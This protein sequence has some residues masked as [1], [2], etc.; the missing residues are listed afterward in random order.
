VVAARARKLLTGGSGRAPRQARADDTANADGPPNS[1]V[2]L[3]AR[4]L[5]TRLVRRGDERPR[6]GVPAAARRRGARPP[7]AVLEALRAP[8]SA[9]PTLVPRSGGARPA[10]L[11]RPGTPRRFSRIPL[12]GLRRGT[13]RARS[14]AAVRSLGMPALRA[15]DRRSPRGGRALVHTVDD[16]RPGRPATGPPAPPHAAPPAADRLRAAPSR[17]TH[18]HSAVRDQPEG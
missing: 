12:P 9:T 17:V 16:A 11:T 10:C 15:P 13:R 3:E 2:V 14:G 18:R 5:A 6:A 1:G 8:R 7:A 4:G